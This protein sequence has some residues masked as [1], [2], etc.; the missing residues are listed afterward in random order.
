MFQ[1][2]PAFK[3]QNSGFEQDT[4]PEYI[5]T[6]LNDVKNTTGYHKFFVTIDEC[7]E[8]NPQFK[9]LEHNLYKT[10]EYFIRTGTVEDADYLRQLLTILKKNNVGIVPEFIASETNDDGFSVIVLKIPGTKT[11]DLIE[12]DKGYNLLESNAKKAAY[13]DFQTLT[14]LGVVNLDV[15]D[16]DCL[17]ITPDKPNK[18]VTKSWS[19]LCTLDDYAKRENTETPGIEIVRKIYKMMFKTN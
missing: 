2:N 19:N 3:S 18:I 15:L 1:F 7:C 11:G 12:Y 17:Q 16:Y 14:K 4:M 9:E 6:L 8:K 10:G 5:K 13:K